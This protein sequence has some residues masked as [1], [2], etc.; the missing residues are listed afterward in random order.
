MGYLAPRL[1]HR[2]R[3]TNRLAAPGPFLLESITEALHRTT[4]PPRDGGRYRTRRYRR[5]TLLV[6]AAPEL[7][8]A[9][10]VVLVAQAQSGHFLARPHARLQF[11]RVES[12][13]SM[14]RTEVRSKAANQRL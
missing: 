6:A 3:Q 9:A 7:F 8:D 5:L 13:D 12:R 10:A 2:G 14:S 1:P 11:D 4:P